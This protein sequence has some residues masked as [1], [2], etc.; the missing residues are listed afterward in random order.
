MVLLKRKDER[1][2]GGPLRCAQGG[3]FKGSP[4]R[5]LLDPAAAQAPRRQARCVSPVA[6]FTI[7]C[8]NPASA[9]SRTPSHRPPFTHHAGPGQ[10]GRGLLQRR[11][12]KGCEGN[13][14]ETINDNCKS[15]C[16]AATLLATESRRG[17]RAGRSEVGRGATLEL[18]TQ[19]RPRGPL[20]ASPSFE[21]CNY[22]EH[23]GNNMRSCA[24]RRRGDREKI[25]GRRRGRALHATLHRL[26]AP[27]PLPQ[28]HRLQR[29]S[30][31]CAL[32]V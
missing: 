27:L 14:M 6:C 23:C 1:K 25:Q 31:E 11:Q 2:G 5:F 13:S 26:V 4:F 12:G 10:Q 21:T 24:Q 28:C 20:P 3:Q 19:R 8:Q 29:A 9:G 15:L 17:R 7:D 18:L 32:L 30:R 22:Y 16:G